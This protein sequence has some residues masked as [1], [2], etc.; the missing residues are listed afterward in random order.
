MGDLMVSASC[1][2]TICV[3]DYQK[4]IPVYKYYLKV[5]KANWCRPSSLQ[6]VQIIVLMMHYTKLTTVCLECC[7]SQQLTA[8][9][10]GQ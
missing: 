7:N 4:R 10:I 1:D 5:C 2:G 9:L 8:T 3:F 6:S